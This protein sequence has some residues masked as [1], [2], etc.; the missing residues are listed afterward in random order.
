M[1]TCRIC[2]RGAHTGTYTP[3]GGGGSQNVGLRRELG[4]LCHLCREP[5]GLALHPPACPWAGIYCHR[6]DGRSVLHNVGRQTLLNQLC[7]HRPHRAL[8][9]GCGRFNSYCV[10]RASGEVGLGRHLPFGVW[11]PWGGCYHSARGHGASEARQPEG[12]RGR[13]WAPGSSHVPSFPG[14][15]ARPAAR[16][17]PRLAP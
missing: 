2:W 14:L 11:T 8:E 5:W 9:G 6:F 12:R 3:P 7:S 13:P 15:S 1:L 10:S 4:G 16:P 17:G